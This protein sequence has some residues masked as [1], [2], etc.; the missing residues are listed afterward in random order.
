MGNIFNELGRAITA[1]FKLVFGRGRKKFNSVDMLA[2]WQEI[3][4][5]LKSGDAL[6]A[7]QAVIQ[8]DTYFDK[9]MKDFGAKGATYADRLRSIK[10]HLDNDAYEQIWRAHKFRNKIAHEHIIVTA[11]EAKAALK[12]LRRGASQLGAF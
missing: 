1:V 4:D 12:S 5:I 6:H 8:A 9:V 7:A 3:E 10:S 2:K 11:R